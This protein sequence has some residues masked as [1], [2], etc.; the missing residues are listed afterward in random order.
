LSEGDSFSKDPREGDD[1]RVQ[2]VVPYLRFD[3]EDVWDIE[4]G[5][6]S[7]TVDVRDIRASSI[8]ERERIAGVR[9]TSDSVST[10]EGIVE[11][12]G[13]GDGERNELG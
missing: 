8:E 4:G 11:V 12:D 9:V 5:E 3:R 6:V 10:I 1:G 7:T 2:P 13:V